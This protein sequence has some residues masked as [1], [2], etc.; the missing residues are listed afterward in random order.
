MTR[1]QLHLGLFLQ[2]AGHHVAG[3]QMPGATY[4]SENLPHLQNVTR[5]AEEAKFDMLFL[6][7]GLTTSPTAHPS[8][9]ARLEPL[10][11]LS[12]LAMGTRHIGLAATASTT[13]GE[14]FHTARVFASLDHLSGGRAGWNVVTTSYARSAANFGKAH[15]DHDARYEIADEYVSVVRALWDSWEDDAYVQDAEEGRYIDPAKMHVLDHKGRYFEVKGPLNVTRPPQG[16][17]VIIQAGSSDPGQEL[18]ARSADVVFTAQATLEGAKAFYDGLKARMAKYGRNPDELAIMPGAFVLIGDTRA[19]AEA[20]LEQLQSRTDPAEAYPLLNERLGTDVSGYDID[21]PLP[22]I[23]VSEEIRS[24]S[25]LLIRLARSRNLTIRQLLNMVGAARGHLMLVGTAE[26]VAD[27]IGAWFEA[28]AADGFNIMPAWF[29]KPLEDFATK[30]VPIL[31]S[32]G[33]FRKD[34]QGR[35]LREH[36]GLK[37]PRHP[38]AT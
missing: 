4:G 11:L 29:P 18:A 6:A 34:Y 23:P 19:E 10:T 25:E 14:P 30:V 28:G 27:E 20:L 8:M 5:I 7:D 38:R 24:R 36:L 9:V 17:P 33:L 22:D 31:Q 15:P 32:R 26:E 35:T 1:K 2:G 21:G 12:A 37:R 16:H 13:Y 3:W